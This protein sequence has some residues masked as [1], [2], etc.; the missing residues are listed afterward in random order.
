MIKVEVIR[1]IM[2]ITMEGNAIVVWL[3]CARLKL[4]ELIK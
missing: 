3:M 2:S 1:P 4:E